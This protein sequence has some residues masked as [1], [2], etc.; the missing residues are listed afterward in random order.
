MYKLQAIKDQ[1]YYEGV[2]ASIT[3]LVAEYG[4]LLGINRDKCIRIRRKECIY[5]G[6]Y[7]H[8]IITDFTPPPYGIAYKPSP[9]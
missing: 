8:I 9:H 7:S 2:F 5:S 1:T 3:D 6:K 4:Q